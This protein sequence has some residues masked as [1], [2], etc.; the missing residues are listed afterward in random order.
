VIKEWR[1]HVGGR[2]NNEDNM[3]LRTAGQLQLSTTVP[4]QLSSARDFRAITVH[5]QPNPRTTA[6]IQNFNGSTLEQRTTFN[7]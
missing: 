3:R 7:T 4:I 1:S 5:E 2:F 6:V